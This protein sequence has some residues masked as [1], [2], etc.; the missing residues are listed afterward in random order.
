VWHGYYFSVSGDAANS[1][2]H[3]AWAYDYDGPSA[4]RY[5]RGTTDS[6]GNILWDQ[7]EQEVIAAS[8]PT[9]YRAPQVTVDSNG[10]PWIGYLRVD[11]TSKHPCVTKSSAKDG[12]WSTAV[13]F[14]YQLSTMN[15]NAGVQPVPL[16]GGK[17]AAVYSTSTHAVNIRSWSGSAWNSE[18]HTTSGG[19]S[20]EYFS[21]VAQSDDV[22]I[23]YLSF[24]NDV[25]YN[26]YVYITNSLGS[27]VKLQA[28]VTS[29]SDPVI[30]IDSSSNDLYCF[31][32]GSPTSNHIYYK[33]YTAAS[34]TWDISPTDW[35]TEP[36]PLAAND[37]LTAFYS[38]HPYIGL[39]YMTS[40]GTSYSVRFFFLKLP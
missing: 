37:R 2:V 1:K 28:M 21:A 7:A 3:Y 18:A 6:S 4:I 15:T 8:S 25:V 33:K 24:G 10:N 39:E 36:T 27:E 23:V 32:A 11:A 12:T 29:T 9:Y 20:A 22:H 30:T 38:G 31:W 35:I 13:G 26:K 19:V 34:S 5:R 16:T 17:M 40:A 14:P